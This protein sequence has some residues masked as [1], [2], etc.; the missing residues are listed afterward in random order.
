MQNALEIFNQKHWLKFH[1]FQC[2]LNVLSHIAY[3]KGVIPFISTN[4]KYDYLIQ[5]TARNVGKY[6]ITRGW[7]TGLFTASNK[8]L[9]IDQLPDKIVAL[10]LQRFERVQKAIMDAAMCNIPV[11]GIVDTDDCDPSLINYPVPGY[12]NS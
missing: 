4:P 7:R 9:G 11:I 6:F 8:M 2:A 12:D 3:K 1:L 5:K 10:N